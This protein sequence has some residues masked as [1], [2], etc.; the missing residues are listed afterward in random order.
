MLNFIKYFSIFWLCL[1]LNS[2]QY[3]SFRPLT[4]KVIKD[5]VWITV[6]SNKPWILSWSGDL[7]NW[8]VM[9]SDFPY[10]GEIQ[11]KVLVDKGW[12]GM[13]SFG[14]YKLEFSGGLVNK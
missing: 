5:D 12:A 2:S 11:V 8:V 4:I 14:Y 7:K 3:L 13:T 9:D 6:I 10:D 1:S